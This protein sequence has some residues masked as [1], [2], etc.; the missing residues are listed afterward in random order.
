M[1]AISPVTLS[2]IQA[3]HNEGF[4]PLVP[5]NQKQKKSRPFAIPNLYRKFQAVKSLQE[6]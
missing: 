3:R 2:H 5:W 4:S 6:A 1:K